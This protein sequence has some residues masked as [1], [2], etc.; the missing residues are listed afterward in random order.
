MSTK[1]HIFLTGAT[2]Y[3]GGSVLQ[4]LLEHPKA[5]SFE[6]TTL[7]RNPDKAKL[8]E[9]FGVKPVIGSH[10]DTDKLEALAKEANVV[11]AVADADDLEAA[12]AI[13]SAQKKRHAET[14]EVPILIHTA[15]PRVISDN[16]AGMFASDV[17]YSDLDIDMIEALKPSQPHRW[18]D[19][20]V[21]N[22]GKQG[23]ARTHIILPSTIYGIAEGVL[24]D[25]GVSNPHSVQVPALIKS[26]WDRQQ[27]GM[28]G[29][30]KN[31]WPCVHIEEIADLYITLFDAA[32]ANPNTPNGREGYYFGESDHYLMYDVAKAVAK[33]LVE[34]GRGKS[35]E[36]TTF[37]K[38]EMQKYFGGV[39]F[40]AYLGSNSR[41]KAERS[42]A[43]GWKTTKTVKD[44][45]AS[46]KPETEA[47]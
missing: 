13:L 9:T 20:F 17:V 18:V 33:T 10:S 8:L 41:C 16:A 46:V 34:L 47:L 29:Q 44:L 5:Q 35:E 39:C 7:V 42:R 12:K 25:K 15:S 23:Y 2:G 6:I 40:S 14:G 21:S 45:L 38:E 3:I 32:T 28:V 36:P 37:T 43:I 19:I 22:E 26:S 30:G 11:F 31:I 27:G 1:T 24:F 4:R